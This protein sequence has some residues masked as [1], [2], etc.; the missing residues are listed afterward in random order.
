MVL[1]HPP[2]RRVLAVGALGVRADQG[3][4][5]MRVRVPAVLLRAGV[6]GRVGFDGGEDHLV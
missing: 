3:G 1:L 2:R 6:L 5:V 4:G